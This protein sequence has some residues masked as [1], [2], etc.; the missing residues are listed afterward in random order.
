[1]VG[2]TRRRLRGAAALIAALAG[3]V[4]TPLAWAAEPR[5]PSEH[6]LF[7]FDDHALPFQHGLRLNLVSYRSATD[8]DGMSN[9]VVPMGPP[10]APDS[11]GLTGARP[12]DGR[13][14]AAY[15]S[16]AD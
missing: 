16:P 2:K 6:V 5:A 13:L 9:V 15:V 7:A 11:K 4:A 3:A 10:G 14:Y 1:M 8:A 12:E